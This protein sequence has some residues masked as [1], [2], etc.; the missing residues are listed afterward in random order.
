MEHFVSKIDPLSE[1]EIS[2]RKYE[3]LH[4]YEYIKQQFEMQIDSQ[5]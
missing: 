5:P 1:K 3:S 4:I 2:L